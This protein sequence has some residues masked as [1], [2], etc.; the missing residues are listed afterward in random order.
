MAFAM[1]SQSSARPAGPDASVLD[2]QRFLEVSR[3]EIPS[4]RNYHTWML[5]S[6][7]DCRGCL[8]IDVTRLQLS[9]PSA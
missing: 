4:L 2:P 5:V 1:A 6:R 9:L 3:H 8:A 7:G